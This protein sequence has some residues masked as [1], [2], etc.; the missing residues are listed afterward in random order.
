MNEQDQPPCQNSIDDARALEEFA[1]RPTTMPDIGVDLYGFATEADARA[2][3]EGVLSLLR[4]IG[5]IMNL[6]RLCQIIVAFDYDKALAELDRGTDVP[7]KTLTRTNDDIAV[8]IAMT[9]TVLRDGE[10]ASVMVLN[11]GYMGVFAEA[12]NQDN[13]ALR[14]EMTYTLAHEC[15]HVHDLHVQETSFPG[16]ILRKPLPYKEGVLSYIASGCWEEYSACRLSAYFG[17]DATLRGYEDTFCLAVNSAK[18][19]ADAAIRQYRMHHDVSRVTDE[20]VAIYKRVMVHASYLFGHL[21]GL[22]VVVA[23]KAPKALQEALKEPWAESLFTELHARLRALHATYDGWGSRDVF[24]PLHQLAHDVLKMGGIDI[25]DRPDGGGHV[26]IP[27]T[28]ETMP[29]LEEQTEFAAA[30]RNKAAGD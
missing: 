25:Q 20:V 18:Q 1:A 10:P 12:D 14:D 5:K 30:R 2:V 3:G 15:G 17:T 13:A 21:D 28:P 24:E 4:V 6:Q 23:D 22:N 8:G 16:D 26:S 9:P 19:R 27:F 7:L 11:A 29:T